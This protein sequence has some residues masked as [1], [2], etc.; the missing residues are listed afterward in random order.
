MT[1]LEDPLHHLRDAHV[2]LAAA[3]PVLLGDGVLAE[4]GQLDGDAVP[5][6]AVVHEPHLPLLP[7][8]GLAAP[9]AVAV[10]AENAAA[11]AKGKGGGALARE[12]VGRTEVRRGVESRHWPM[13]RKA[14][15]EGGRLK[16]K[17]DEVQDGFSECTNNYPL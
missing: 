14:R 15:S 5:A 17:E 2:P 13:R 8:R 11:A 10:G 7:D 6:L 12:K 4:A 1:E 3:E 9:A 16:T